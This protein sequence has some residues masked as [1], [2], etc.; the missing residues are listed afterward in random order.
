LGN[1]ACLYIGDGGKDELA[2]AGRAGMTAVLL[3]S[4]TI[5]VPG[6]SREWVYDVDEIASVLSLV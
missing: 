1:R 5:S 6:E 4:S 2:G 3:R